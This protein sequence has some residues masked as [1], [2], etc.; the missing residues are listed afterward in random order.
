MRI[1]SLSVILTACVILLTL[2]SLCTSILAFH[3]LEKRRMA[4]QSVVDAMDACEMLLNGSDTLTT[5]IRGYA[6]TGDEQF[7]AAYDTELYQAK[8]RDR[9]LNRLQKL[10]LTTDEL[11]RLETAKFNSDALVKLELRIF[12]TA[13]K[14][15]FRSATALAW[16][17]EYRLS[18][19]SVVDPIRSARGDLQTRLLGEATR[20]SNQARIIKAIAFIT[21]TANFVAVILALVWFFQRRV[22][23]PLALL[24]NRTRKLLEGDHSVDFLGQFGQNEVGDLARAMM[25]FKKSEESIAHQRWINNGLVDIVS[26][27][28]KA[29]TY[30]DF[31]K[32]VLERLCPMLHAGIAIMFFRETPEAPLLGISGFGISAAHVKTFSLPSGEGLPHEALNLNR[33]IIL[34]E[35][36]LGHFPILTGLGQS[37]PQVLVMIPLLAKEGAAAVLEMA[38]FTAPSNTQWGLIKELPRVLSPH[39][40][41]L[42]RS[43]RSEQLL[44]ATQTQATALEKQ[45]IELN[46]AHI[47]LKA[48]FDAATFG[49]MLIESSIIR[50]CNSRLDE[51]LGHPSGSMEGKSTRLLFF[52]EEDWL[53]WRDPIQAFLQEGKVFQ[54]EQQFQRIDGSRFQ[55]RVTA[56]SLDPN[57]LS[58][59]I[60][61]VL[62]DITAEW[63]AAEALRRAAEE[64][65]A[66]FEAASSG[67]VLV[68]NR[69]IKRCNRRIEEM[70]G[71]GPDELLGKS[72]RSWYTSEAAF[73]DFGKSINESLAKGEP[74]IHEQ[75]M[76]KKDGS[77][78]WSRVRVQPAYRSDLTMGVVGLIDDITTER[79]NQE[80]LERAVKAAEQANQAKSL[81]LANMSHEIRTPLNAVLGYTQLLLRDA[82]LQASQ[83]DFVETIHRSGHHLLELINGV[84]EMSKIEAGRVRLELRSFDFPCLLS[85]LA[86]MFRARMEEK[87]LAF[88]LDIDGCVPKYLL[89]DPVKIKQVMINVVGNALKFTE[90]GTV[91]VMVKAIKDESKAPKVIVEVRDTGIGIPQK[92]LSKVFEA[93]EQASGGSCKGGTGLGMA[94][95][96]QYAR[97]LGGDLTVESRAGEGSLFRFT[98]QADI[99]ATDDSGR[100][101]KVREVSGL[102][103]QSKV[104]KVLVVDDISENRDLLRHLLG[105]FGFEVS[106]ATNGQEALDHLAA[107]R[108]DI[109]LMD[110]VMPVMSGLEAT[111]RIKASEAWRNIPIIMLTASALEE[112]RHRAGEAGVDGYLKKPL[113]LGDILDTLQRCVPGVQFTYTDEEPCSK[114]QTSPN[115]P[116]PAQAAAHLSETIRQDLCAFVEAGDMDGFTENL[117]KRIAPEDPALATQ[118]KALAERFDYRRILGI[119]Q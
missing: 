115:A 96:R 24:T 16:G 99:G 93:F 29:D 57:D 103:P 54:K 32:T 97:L 6:A 119:L 14:Q 5:A 17:P 62:E 118:L 95:S 104:A 45:S 18:K 78:F 3:Q 50:Q 92:E 60:V 77:T 52:S 106:E 48:I 53:A 102:A 10:N 1:K 110:W 65:Q 38:C 70:F 2:T 36:P 26:H 69:I 86:T 46:T 79:Q 44:E 27:A 12:A 100:R 40:E 73:L 94:I 114:M 43:R 89:T 23:S 61:A 81:F 82:S 8:T 15:D 37:Q 90:Q 22:V 4:R 71:Y 9:A 91:K 111:R 64:Q 88:T 20:L 34:Q 13:E 101:K 51:I 35:I 85:D 25:D 31:G 98:F 74:F 11:H 108:P 63:E 59:G 67:I 112:S 21:H 68:R 80:S 107:S 28:Q 84:L 39:L 116:D 49:I 105:T 33:P 83:R 109:I 56:R 72:T 41:I 87:G 47:R 7:R 117:D 66:I 75:L 42:L 55:G 76:V 113:H 58:R 19:A 30:E